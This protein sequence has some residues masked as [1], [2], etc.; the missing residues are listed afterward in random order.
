M[1]TAALPQ[2]VPAAQ[3][4]PVAARRSARLHQGGSGHDAYHSL[5]DR[6]KS[7]KQKE[8]LLEL[9]LNEMTNGALLNGEPLP[10]GGIV[11]DAADL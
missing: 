2:A 1:E 5:S 7:L 11:I 4:R 8:E 10:P 6:E 9:M 3:I